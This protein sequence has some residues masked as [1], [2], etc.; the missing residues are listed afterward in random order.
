MKTLE[1]YTIGCLVLLLSTV[2]MGQEEKT[3]EP[4]KAA[5]EPYKMSESDK[6]VISVGLKGGV[7]IPQVSSSMTTTFCPFSK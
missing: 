5:E 2:A 4:S 6:N 1:M 3:S 7:S